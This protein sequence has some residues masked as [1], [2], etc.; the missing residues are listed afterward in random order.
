M[1]QDRKLN[2][3]AQVLFVLQSNKKSKILDIEVAQL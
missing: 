1:A 3:C 2:V